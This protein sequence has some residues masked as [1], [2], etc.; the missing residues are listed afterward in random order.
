M[1]LSPRRRGLFGAAATLSLLALLFARR[2]AVVSA[3]V[4]WRFSDVPSITPGDLA[5]MTPPPVLVDARS[6]EEFAVGHLAG[7]TRADLAHP[8]DALR[9]VPVGRAVVVYCSVG[10]RSGIAARVLRARGF[11]D[12][13]NL[14]GGVFAWAA[15]GRGMVGEGGPT[16]AVHPYSRGWGLLRAGGTQPSAR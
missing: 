7:A 8:E 5:A 9:G 6:P 12:V 10:H 14:R 2:L 15:E 4:A 13:R 11:R 16:R 1:P 3:L